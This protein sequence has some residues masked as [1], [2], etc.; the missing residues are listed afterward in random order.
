MVDDRVDRA[1]N[2]STTGCHTTSTRRE[3]QACVCDLRASGESPRVRL[4]GLYVCLVPRN[5]ASQIAACGQ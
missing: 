3:N 5:R 2:G 1:C 4:A